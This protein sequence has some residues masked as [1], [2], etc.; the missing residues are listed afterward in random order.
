VGRSL[1]RILAGHDLAGNEIENPPKFHIGVAGAPGAEPLEPEILKIERKIK[2]GGE[3]IQTQVIYDMEIAKRFL[4]AVKHLKVPTLI[5]ICPLKSYKMAKWMDEFCPGIFVPPEILE[6]LKKIQDA[7]KEERRQKT[8]EWNLNFF[9]G[10]L[11]EL[12]KTTSAAGCHIMAVGFE[13]I[14]ADIVKLVK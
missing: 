7:P 3:F 13:Y 11:K 6:D 1:D 5:G 2:V 10:W 14:V 9:E 12:K 4:D 8:D